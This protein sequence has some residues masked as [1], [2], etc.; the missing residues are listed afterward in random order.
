V[1]VGG[2]LT[3]TPRVTGGRRRVTFAE[4]Q[5]TDTDSHLI[6]GAAAT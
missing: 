2:C 1:N 6:A 4:A 3:G 5:I